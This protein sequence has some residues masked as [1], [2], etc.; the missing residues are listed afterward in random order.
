MDE[1]EYNLHHHYYYD[2]FF[3]GLDLI[4]EIEA[5]SRTVFSVESQVSDKRPEPN[6]PVS[7]G[8]ASIFGRYAIADAV[9]MAASA[10]VCWGLL[11]Y[12]CQAS[13]FS[14]I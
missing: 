1:R 8:K 3:L 5:S 7:G 12:H 2:D 14:G 13:I 6:A 9:D 4:V 11:V 10:V